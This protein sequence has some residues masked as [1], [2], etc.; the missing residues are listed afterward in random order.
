MPAK[1]FGTSGIRGS[2]ENLF[3]NDFCVRAGFVFGEWLNRKGKSG[4]VAVAMDPRESSPRIKSYVIRGLAAAGW[5]ILDEGVIPTPALTYFVKNSP[6]V[7][8]GMMITGSHITADL[9]GLK[10]LFDGEEVTKEH[11]KEIESIFAEFEGKRIQ[12][13]DAIVKNDQDGEDIYVAMLS[14]L[15]RRINPK[16]K[17]VVDS[18][19]GAQTNIFRRLF[20]DWKIKVK[21]LGDG[22][23][24]SPNFVPR[25]T[26]VPAHFS[27][28]TRHVL[29]AKADFGIGF[30]VDGDRVIFVDNRGR[31]IPGDYSCSLIA[32]ESDSYAIVTPV[33]SSS[34]VD[35]IG[36]KVFRTPVGST[37]VAAKM[38]EV[39]ATLGFEANGGAISAEISYGRDGGT[40]AVKILNILAQSG[41]KLSTLY[42]SLPKL[43]LFRDKIDCPFDKYDAI[44]SLAKEK[45]AQHR[46][47]DIDGIKIYLSEDDWLLFRGSGNAPE[48]RIFAQ[49][50]SQ[51][52]ADR[53]GQ[54]G[55][56]L[57]RSVI[58]PYTDFQKTRTGSDS[59][60]VFQ[61]IKQFDEQCQQ[62]IREIAAIQIP[63]SCSLVENIVVSGMGGSALGGRILAGLER[64]VL[65]VPMLVSTEYHLPNFVGSKTLVVVSSYSG[66]TEESI[67]SLSEARAR[68]AQIFIIASGGRLAELAKTYD[69][70]S[71]IFDPIHNP[72]GQP[73][74]GLGYNLMALVSILARCQL[75]APPQNLAK[76]PQY[77]KSNFTI[78]QQQAKSVAVQIS[79]RI[80]VILASEHLKG[81]AHDFKN[82]FNENAKT[83]AVYFDLPE[84]NHHLL[85]GLTFPKSN[86]QNLIGLFMKSVHYATPVQKRY[87][88]TIN[89]FEKQ[90]I[91][92]VVLSVKADSPLFEVLG[93]LQLA[94]LTAFELSQ[95]NGIDPGPIPWVEYFKE[96]LKG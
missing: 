58:A 79:G 32:R 84:A 16:W 93:C 14:N 66:N 53:L 56:Q 59:M 87:D 37:R 22:D 35:R 7:A 90:H 28:L 12:G 50:S 73:R 57:V 64:Q 96:E 11:E 61:S 94:A 52:K 18:A 82:Q 15:A 19:N 5:E 51:Q 30:D 4:F 65:K 74:L 8:G 83:F 45:Y 36:K 43:A 25:D 13:M 77:L 80:P 88:L 20:I 92:S 55:L 38:K 29:L 42:D 34:V 9:N 2:A 63:S 41:A 40:T 72:S 75:I 89:V 3:T 67:A 6:H 76:V 69:L 39:G 46:I 60:S 27:E 10:L 24:Q 33:S 81:V 31:Y 95:I 62:V 21:Y 54:T 26:E 85:E 44:Y 70:P 71:Y 78:H 17:I 1:L 91:P 48:F 49:S 23:I 47:E 86:T 68:N